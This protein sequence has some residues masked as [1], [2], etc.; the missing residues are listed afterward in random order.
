M[1]DAFFVDVDEN[2]AICV[3]GELIFEE[4]TAGG[5][6]GGI[7]GEAS[8]FDL[9]DEQLVVFFQ[10]EVCADADFDG[11]IVDE[12]GPPAANLSL[13]DGEA[14]SVEELFRVGFAADGLSISAF[15]GASGSTSRPQPTAEQE[16]QD[17]NEGEPL[18]TEHGFCCIS[19][20]G[21]FPL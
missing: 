3:E 7:G 19:T 11:L 4:L 2:D 12:H 14:L 16:D 10:E 21:Y 1:D 20:M 13:E 6:E 8:G 17:A 5:G 9:G 15:C 18:G